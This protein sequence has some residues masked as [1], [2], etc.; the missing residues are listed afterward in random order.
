LIKLARELEA[1]IA[2]GFTIELTTGG[3]K[4]DRKELQPGTVKS[5]LLKNFI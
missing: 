3:N 5:E 4:K 2:D 1:D